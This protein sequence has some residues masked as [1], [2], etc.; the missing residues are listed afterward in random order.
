MYPLNKTDYGYEFITSKKV[1][2]DIY[3]TQFDHTSDAEYIIE[4]GLSPKNLFYFGFY[5]KQNDVKT[6]HDLFIMRTI[7]ITVF[8]FF[9]DFQEGILVFNYKDSELRVK[10]KRKKFK[11][12]FDAYSENTKIK[13]LQ[14]DFKDEASVC[15]M[16]VRGS[17]PN[18]HNI[19]SSI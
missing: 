4:K 17:H 6:G 18:F 9:H 11:Q 5:K 19:V 1:K 16:Y 14:I 2:Y 8:Q 13:L 7:A 10:A 12:I 15:A 3:F